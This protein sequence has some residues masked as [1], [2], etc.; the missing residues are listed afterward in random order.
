[1]FYRF[2][3]SQVETTISRGRLAWHEGKIEVSSGSS[4]FVPTPPGGPMFDGLQAWNSLQAKVGESV[5]ATVA[6]P[7]MAKDEL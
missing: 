6:S 7:S 1:L 2:A 4:R 3:V 5:E